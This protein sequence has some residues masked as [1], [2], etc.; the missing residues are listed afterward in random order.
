MYQFG[1]TAFPRRDRERDRYRDR[2]IED[3]EDRERYTREREGERERYKK[4]RETRLDRHKMPNIYTS[5]NCGSSRTYTF[6][7][8][9]SP[10]ITFEVKANA[11][12]NLCLSPNSVETPHQ[13]IE[14]FL[15]GWGG[16]ES[17]LRRNKKD[18]VHKTKTPGVVSANLFRGFWITVEPHSIK[19]GKKGEGSPFL[20]HSDPF[21]NF[22]F[23]FYGYCTSYGTTGQW[24]FDDDNIG[25]PPPYYPPVPPPLPPTYAHPPLPLIQVSTVFCSSL[26]R[27]INSYYTVKWVQCSTL[28]MCPAPVQV[29]NGHNLPYVAAAFHNGALLPGYV[30][31]HQPNICN[32]SWGG[33]A[34][35]KMDF[36]LLSNPGGADFVWQSGSFGSAP[37]GALQGG[38]TETGE[39]LYIGRFKQGGVYVGGKVHPSH[40]V[41]YAP[42]GGHEVRNSSYEVL[43]L[44]SVPLSLLGL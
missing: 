40:S 37:N 44:K 8:I 27:H 18:D 26:N 4:E 33:A 3:I 16:G 38:Y 22:T 23:S 17:A 30:T 42:F 15:A 13:Q 39:R 29:A 41:C 20:M 34:H 31:V 35:Q 2:D 25:V 32:V 19:V 21:V 10:T 36:F 7:P 9:K 12:V 11:N 1:R 14:I 24:I 6:R 5:E 28:S 43:C